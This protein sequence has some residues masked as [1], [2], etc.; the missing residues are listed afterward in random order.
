MCFLPFKE[1]DGGDDGGPCNA[2]DCCLY[3]LVLC[4]TIRHPY[5]LH[6]VFHLPNHS[7]QVELNRQGQYQSL[8]SSPKTAFNIQ[9][10][11]ASKYD[12]KGNAHAHLH[13]KLKLSCGLKR[14]LVC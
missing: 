9:F 10:I 3:S 8:N 13:Y 4:R 14:C 7:H 11:V 2:Y 5:L 1:R 6:T 12:C